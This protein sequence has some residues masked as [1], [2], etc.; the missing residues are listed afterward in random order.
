MREK[1][2][3]LYDNLVNGD[4]Y[5]IINCYVRE[6]IGNEE[7]DDSDITKELQDMIFYDYGPEMIYFKEL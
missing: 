6:Q 7:Y 4:L 3:E 1:I 2:K 5:E